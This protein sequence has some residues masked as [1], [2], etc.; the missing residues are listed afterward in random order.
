VPVEEVKR[1]E[2]VRSTHSDPARPSRGR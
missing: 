2:Q 1:I